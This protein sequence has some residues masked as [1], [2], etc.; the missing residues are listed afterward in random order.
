[1]TE[2]TPSSEQVAVNSTIDDEFDERILTEHQSIP[3]DVRE[4]ALARDGH[5]CRID[6][7]R[8]TGQGDSTQLVVQRVSEHP[9]DC[10]PDDVENV[11]TYCLRC[12]RWVA[13]MPS[14]DDLPPVVQDRL[15]SADLDTDHVEILQY[16]HK[17]GP[18]QTS[19]V[20][21]AVDRRS[22]TSVRR[23]IYDL[24]SRDV[25]DDDVSG[26]L[27]AKDRLAETYGLFWQIPKERDARGVIPLRPHIRRSRILDAVAV[28]ILD[29]L[30]GRV[31]DPR[32]IA[33]EVV[34]RD[35]NQTYNME[36]R[37]RAFQFPFERWANTKRARH[38]DAAAVEA[39]SVF[40][41][42]TDNLS[43]RRIAGPLVDM[44]ERNEEHELAAVLR[45]SL[46]EDAD[47]PFDTLTRTPD[48]E[49]TADTSSTDEE[50]EPTGLH[51]FENTNSSRRP[52]HETTDTES[53]Q[54]DT[55]RE[56]VDR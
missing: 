4:E 27:V 35:R 45:Q 29:A 19:E 38:D 25:S 18:A 41:A 2:N 53:V 49:T 7:C 34:D 56:G 24:M 50:N 28:R 46:L 51:V 10:A 12:A 37:E 14:R 48:R 44:L 15:D 22:T 55:H 8:G 21:E 31:E 47:S 52:K 36:K 11:T 43:R 23:V 9:R 5:R 40:A 26:R 33:A 16:L 6:G 42:A 20:T 32:K 1:M 39:I 3:S 30:D 17:N 13:Q 54:D